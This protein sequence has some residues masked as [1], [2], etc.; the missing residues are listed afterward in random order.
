MSEQKEHIRINCILPGIVATKIIPPEM[1]AAVSAEWQV[2]CS[3]YH[4]LEAD[5]PV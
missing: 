5:L 1:V 3:R 2:K 4:G